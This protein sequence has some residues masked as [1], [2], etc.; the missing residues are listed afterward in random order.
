MSGK[1]YDFSA[2]LVHETEKASLLDCGQ[3]EPIWFPKSVT[4]ENGDG[5]WT[6]PERWAID[7]GIV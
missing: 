7:K 5:T 1:L 6:V 3:G 2:V 4:E